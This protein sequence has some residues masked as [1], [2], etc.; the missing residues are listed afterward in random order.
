MI[1]IFELFLLLETIKLR[2]NIAEDVN[3]FIQIKYFREK[4]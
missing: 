3:K 1:I 4:V 2:N